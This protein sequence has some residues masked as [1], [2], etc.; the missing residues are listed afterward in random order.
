MST[1][2]TETSYQPPLEIK[3]VT[4][5]KTPSQRTL[6]NLLKITYCVK[7]EYHKLVNKKAVHYIIMTSTFTHN[8]MVGI[9]C[10]L[11]AKEIF[12]QYR[13][14]NWQPNPP[15]IPSIKREKINSIRVRQT[16]KSP[17]EAWARRQKGG[18]PQQRTH[19]Q[20][21]FSPSLQKTML[22]SLKKSE[23]NNFLTE[24][25]SEIIKSS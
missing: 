6:N 19:F 20:K 13:W 21:L 9:R 12:K 18:K 11:Y 22:Q 16:K 10:I 3:L 14:S 23:E 4:A 15:L 24:L 17:M 2:N 5:S 25:P 1:Q 8:K 7:L